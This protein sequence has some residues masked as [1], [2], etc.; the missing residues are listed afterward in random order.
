MGTRSPGCGVSNVKITFD[1]ASE[2]EA[3]KATRRRKKAWERVSGGLVS[4]LGWGAAGF[5]F[6]LGWVLIPFFFM[7]LFPLI[8]GLRSLVAEGIAA[9]ALKRTSIKDRKLA[10]ERNILRLASSRGGILSPALVSI[11]TGLSLE[12]A[13]ASLDAIVGKGHAELRILESGRLEYA[14]PE[15]ERTIR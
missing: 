8:S 7:G 4:C 1:S 15:F 5:I 9:P 2:G 3:E 12:E 11:E 10:A 14:F 13:Q 6:H